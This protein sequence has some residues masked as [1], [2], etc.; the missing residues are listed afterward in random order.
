MKIKSSS[1]ELMDEVSEY[2]SGEILR[3]TTHEV[4]ETTRFPEIAYNSSHVTTRIG[5]NLFGAA[6]QGSLTLHGITNRMNFTSQ[7]VV[8]EDALRGYGNFVVNQSEYGIT[9]ASVADGTLKMKDELKV[10]FFI[11]ARKQG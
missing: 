7:V 8:G 9:I 3:V 4:L 2:D 1:L 5:E 11:G 10:A 6:V